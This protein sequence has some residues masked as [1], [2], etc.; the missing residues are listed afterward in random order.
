MQEISQDTL[1]EDDIFHCKSD[2]PKEE[3][4]FPDTSQEI[5]PIEDLP[6]QT[7]NPSPISQENV[8]E[9]KTIQQT[10]PKTQET[11]SGE[12]HEQYLANSQKTIPEALKDTSEETQ[13]KTSQTTTKT[14]VSH[15]QDCSH[16]ITSL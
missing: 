14:P 8:Q 6:E 9:T 15:D 2:Q 12:T 1:P 16:F 11:S 5:C 13:E 3:E 7:I 10:P 4:T